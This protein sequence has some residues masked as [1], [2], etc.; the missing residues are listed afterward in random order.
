MNDT[1]LGVLIASGFTFAN[2]IIMHIFTLLGKRS[3]RKT[4]IENKKWDFYIQ[5]RTEA[6]QEYF[7]QATSIDLQSPTDEDIHRLIRAHARL[8]LFVSPD[9][10]ELMNIILKK[11]ETSIADDHVYHEAFNP[12]GFILNVVRQINKEL[13]F[14]KPPKNFNRPDS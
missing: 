14:P 8:S 12:Y 13:Q 6:A 10:L 2:T 5:K 3:D 11:F 4:V 7:D 1:L 9:T